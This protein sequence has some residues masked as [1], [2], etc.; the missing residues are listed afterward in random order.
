MLNKKLGGIVAA[1]VLCGGLA[2]GP[3][4]ADDGDTETPV[5]HAYQTQ[6]SM[7]GTFVPM[8]AG[9]AKGAWGAPA[10]IPTAENKTWTA[11][12]GYVYSYWFHTVDANGNMI[13]GAT[14]SSREKGSITHE[15]ADTAFR[16]HMRN[17]NWGGV[18]FDWA[19]E[20]SSI[21]ASVDKSE[22]ASVNGW[23]MTVYEG[24][25]VQ[26]DQEIPFVAYMVEDGDTA[27]WCI[28]IADGE[29]T[30]SAKVREAARKSAQ[31]YRSGEAYV[32]A[33]GAPLL[34]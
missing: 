17:F 24:K 12:S 19:Y 21:T 9:A 11:S 1:T 3:A 22:G 14:P 31:S 28:V 18:S 16:A 4:L 25:L 13:F 34:Y 2:A 27:S 20:K 7:Q 15:Q 26:R 10:A 29:T 30:S 6:S 33:S 8:L 23:E 32:K 5:H